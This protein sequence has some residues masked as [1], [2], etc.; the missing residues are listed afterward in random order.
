MES[1][2]ASTTSLG[3]ILPSLT[4]SALNVLPTLLPNDTNIGNGTLPGIVPVQEGSYILV[5]TRAPAHC[6]LCIEHP[7]RSFDRADSFHPECSR[8]QP[9]QA[10]SCQTTEHTPQRTKTRLDAA[11]VARWNGNVHVSRDEESQAAK[12]SASQVCESNIHTNVSRQLVHRWHCNTCGLIGLHR[13]D[14]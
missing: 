7:D 12:Y 3:D 1:I 10:R 14:R 11:L 5:G 6:S 13:W 4:S 8:S 2:I 9:H